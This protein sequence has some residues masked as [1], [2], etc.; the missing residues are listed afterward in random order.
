ML[1]GDKVVTQ[2]EV[3]AGTITDISVAV[4]IN[5]NSPNAESATIEQLT[6]Q[7]AVA[8]GIGTSV[9]NWDS[10]V[11]ILIA[12]F[13]ETVP[14]GEPSEPGD[15]TFI[16]GVPNW[17]VLA[18][19]AGVVLFLLL[20]ILILVLR[21]RSRKKKLAAQLAAEAEQRALEEA[22]A[23]AEAAAVIAAAPTGGADIMEVNTEKSMELRKT[24]RQFAQ[25]NPEIAAQMV[26]AWLKG[27]ENGG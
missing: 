24:V 1:F 9:E 27:D 25:N 8:S 16:P 23:A 13:H 21:S 26:R 14:S 22:A 3:L 15:T 5:R 2:K 19:L 12:P 18:A 20:L 11:S 7:V 6:R 10:H 4:T 17:V